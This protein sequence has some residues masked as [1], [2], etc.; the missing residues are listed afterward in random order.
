MVKEEKVNG[1][2]DYYV[3]EKEKFNCNDKYGD[4]QQDKQDNVG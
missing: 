3:S 2:N 1:K 4:K